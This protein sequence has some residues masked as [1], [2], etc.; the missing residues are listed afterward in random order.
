MSNVTP[1]V[2]RSTDWLHPV[3]RPAFIK[4]ASQLAKDF[5][6]GTLEYEFRIFE[7]YRT[8][9]RQ[10]IVAAQGNSKA[11][12]FR[13]AHQFGLAVDFVPFVLGRGFTWDVPVDCW[14]HLRSRA[15]AAGMICDIPWDR[16]H[17]EHPLWKELRTVMLLWK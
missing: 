4:L 3:A 15:G 6:D 1:I 11:Q 13:S 14:D 17:I 8:P 16:A 7:T 2:E 5:E 10:A 12:A 9:Q